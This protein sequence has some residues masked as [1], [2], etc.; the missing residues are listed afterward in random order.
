MAQIQIEPKRSGTWIWVLII[1]VIIIAIVAWLIAG[2]SASAPTPATGS[3]TGWVVP[4]G[5][6]AR[7]G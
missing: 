1:V 6:L 7:V 2:R 3:T 5:A 4:A